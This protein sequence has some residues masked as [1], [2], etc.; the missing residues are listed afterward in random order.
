MPKKKIMIVDDDKEFLEE[1]KETLNL[2][3]YDTVGF[4]DGVSAL[5]MIRKI[6]P[7]LI[8]LDLKM[9][10][11]NGFQV[12][13]ELKHLPD[14]RVPI[15]TMSAFFTEREYT[16]LMDVCGIQ[17]CLIKPFNPLEAISKIEEILQE[18]R[19]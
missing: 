19:G 18:R 13:Y 12:A 4:S 11:K 6:K 16:R 10:Q 14:V 15:I 2:S 9:S 17:T 3:G 1:L 7:D 8:M 5:E